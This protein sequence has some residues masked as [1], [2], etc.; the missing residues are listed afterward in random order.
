M[1]RVVLWMLN[2]VFC[3][4]ELSASIYLGRLW[5]SLLLSLAAVLLSEHVTVRDLLPA[6]GKSERFMA[7]M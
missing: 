7:C 5:D 1:C 2:F 4:N 6:A 3:D